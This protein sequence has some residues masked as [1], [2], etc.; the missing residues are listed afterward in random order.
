MP[1]LRLQFTLWDLLSATF[2]VAVTSAAWAVTVNP[3]FVGPLPLL[4]ALA[5]FL[6]P[7]MA[8]GALF[9]RVPEGILGCLIVIGACYFLL[10]VLLV[11]GLMH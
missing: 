2:W 10:A 8:I 6:A 4:S 7:L 3:P 9:G 11:T 1:P 5:G